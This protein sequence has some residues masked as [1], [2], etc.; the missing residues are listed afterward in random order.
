MSESNIS[1]P[2]CGHSFNPEEAIAKGVEARL[3]EEFQKKHQDFLK[4]QGEKKDQLLK[5]K[6][7]F[8]EQKKRFDE[9]QEKARLE[10]AQKL[11][12]DRERLA[13][14]A[15]VKAQKDAQ[16]GME[17]IVKNLREDLEK[18]KT[19]NKSLQQKELDFLKKEQEMKEAKEQMDLEIQKRVLQGQQALELKAKE[20]IASQFELKE[21]EYQKQIEDAKKS[22]IEMK[23][24]MEQGSMQLQG[25]VQ[26]LAIEDELRSTFPFDDI[27]EVSKGIRGADCVQSIKNQNQEVVGKII[28]E[29]KRTS[30]FGGDWIEKL[31]GDMLA[32]GADVAVLITQTLPKDQKT[33]NLVNGVWV[34]SFSEF[35]SLAL[36]LREGILKVSTALSANENKGDKMHMLY[37]YLTGNEF[38]HQIESII[39]AFQILEEDLA[40]EKRAMQLIW[41]KREK[42]IEKVIANTSGLYG[43]VKGIAGSSIKKIDALELD[44]SDDLLEDDDEDDD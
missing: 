13:N 18:K 10:Y 41:K 28:Y 1:C 26:E 32:A 2:Q 8:V 35:K 39:G 29:S 6:E 11:K 42:Q 38:R 36:A 24:K 33:F 43:A 31:K 25:E 5:Q 21:K 4:Q 17:V 30:N 23:R 19:E 15:K 37:S 44:Y 20:K 9:A 40:K 3:T 27:D 7:E 14:E 34:C 12:E 22:A 16:E